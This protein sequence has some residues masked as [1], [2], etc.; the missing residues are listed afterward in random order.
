MNDSP[1]REIALIDVQIV[2]GKRIDVLN[3]CLTRVL[4]QKEFVRHIFIANNTGLSLNINNPLITV[5]DNEHPLSFECNHNRLA[6]LG[7]SE[8]LLF[9][10]DDA[11]IFPG[12]VNTLFCRIKDDPSILLVSGVNNQIYRPV[13]PDIEVPKVARIEDFLLSEIVFAELSQKLLAEKRHIWQ[14]RIFSPGSLIMTRRETWLYRYGGWDEGYQNWNEEI[15]YVLWGYENGL[16]TLQTN[17][18][19]YFHCMSTSRSSE[20]LLGDIFNSSVHFLEKFTEE[21]LDVIRESLHRFNPDLVGQ[22][23]GLVGFNRHCSCRDNVA[24]SDYYLKIMKHLN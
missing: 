15:D 5:L 11:F 18:V 2:A 7:D 22:L 13:N 3:E 16:K 14:E 19:W 10:D 1:K 17:S 24:T 23:E 4:D 6:L 21:R 9:L 12:C 20:R 8:Y